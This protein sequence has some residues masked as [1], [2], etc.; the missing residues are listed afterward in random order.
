M[1][2][3]LPQIS[4][5]AVLLIAVSLVLLWLLGG[6]LL[7]LFVGVLLAA[8]LDAAVLALR[9][10]IPLPRALALTIVV[11]LV[12]GAVG[13]V[14]MIGGPAIWE[15]VDQLIGLFESQREEVGRLLA[16]IAEPLGFADGENGEGI[17]GL[18]PDMGSVFS[19]AGT[20]FGMTLGLA[21]NILVVVFVGLF[22]AVDPAAYRDSL[23]RLTPVD[24]RERLAEV[25]D[26]AGAALR[27]W[28]VGQ[29]ALM[30]FIGL[31]VWLMLMLLGIENAALLGVV[32]GL[33]NFVPY[34]GPII[35]AIPVVLSAVTLE[36]PI[37][38]AVVGLYLIIQNVEGYILSPLVQQRAVHLQPGW[39]MI[40]LVLLG[41]LFGALGIAV[42][43]PLFAVL[44]VLVRELYIKDIL[45]RP[46]ESMLKL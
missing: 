5:T 11:L 6:T 12:L 30:A 27:W 14:G 26:K 36:L 15:Q 31:S 7:V 13:T 9:S 42:A 8:M 24:R 41:T 28:I 22:L 39:S 46:E 18:L 43:I 29:L 37:L 21:G 20:A 10:V 16:D 25:L 32:A 4:T 38:I 17:S 2:A 44:R 45:E 1:P 34:L 40:T 19:T 3:A 35:A 33:L 23:V